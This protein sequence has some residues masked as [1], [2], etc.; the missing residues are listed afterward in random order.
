MTDTAD[1]VSISQGNVHLMRLVESIE[2]EVDHYSEHCNLAEII[3][4][5]ELVKVNVINANL[6]G[7]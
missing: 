4:A 1:V 3:G 5:L 2:N 7:E 6:Y